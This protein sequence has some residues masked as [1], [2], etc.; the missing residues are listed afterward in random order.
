MLYLFWSEG[1]INLTAICCYKGPVAQ[2]TTRLTTNQKIAGS[3]PARITCLFEKKR[4]GG[5]CL[6]TG[7]A[8]NS[9]PVAKWRT[10]PTGRLQVLFPPFHGHFEKSSNETSLEGGGGRGGGGGAY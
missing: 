4:R 7:H 8:A 5:A 2:W 1:L 6:L 10:R 9:G 3:S